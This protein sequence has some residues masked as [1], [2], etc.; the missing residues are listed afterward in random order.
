MALGTLLLLSAAVLGATAQQGG[1]SCSACNCQFNN[2][3][4]FNEIIDARID[5]RLNIAESRINSTIASL[6]SSIS[7]FVSALA[8]QPRK[9]RLVGFTTCWGGH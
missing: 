6:N 2:V 3:D 7:G 5:A 9:D 8:D 4:V 1:G